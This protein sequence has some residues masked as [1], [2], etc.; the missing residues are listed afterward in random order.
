MKA[1]FLLI[2]FLEGKKKKSDLLSTEKMK[3]SH[4]RV[5][6]VQGSCQ[7]TSKLSPG[8][9][10]PEISDPS[11]AESP[12]GPHSWGALGNVDAQCPVCPLGL[13]LRVP[14]GF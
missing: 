8:L 1:A 10:F 5:L 13:S 4:L 9:I 7:T 2:K 6:L 11:G 3:T 14:Q 12:G